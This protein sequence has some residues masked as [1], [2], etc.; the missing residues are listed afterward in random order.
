MRAEGWKIFLIPSRIPVPYGPAP[1]F[2]ADEKLAF[3]T[4]DAGKRAC[5]S[6]HDDST[7]W[8]CGAADDGGFPSVLMEPCR[9][10]RKP[11][12]KKWSFIR[13]MEKNRLVD[14][15]RSRVFLIIGKNVFWKEIRKNG[16]FPVE[17]QKSRAH[18][19]SAGP[20][21]GPLLRFR[22][23]PKTEDGPRQRRSRKEGLRLQEKNQGKY[24]GDLAVF[25]TALKKAGAHVYRRGAV[26]I[27][28]M[29]G[30]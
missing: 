11:M 21:N 25:P 19:R 28:A 12:E 16:K 20:E 13:P 17:I 24:S 2:L 5:F 9:D 7:G 14:K 26:A 8:P 22:P 3:G 23:T 27:P 10:G 1:K 29:D 30:R 15:A 6:N 4:G 18:W